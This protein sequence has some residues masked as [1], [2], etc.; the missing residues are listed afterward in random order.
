LYVK[1][2]GVAI[3][4]FETLPRRLSYDGRPLTK[5]HTYGTAYTR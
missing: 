5:E 3:P 2:I 4:I 1:V